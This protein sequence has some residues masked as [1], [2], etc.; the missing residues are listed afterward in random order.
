MRLFHSMGSGAH[1]TGM[2]TQR[3]LQN[4]QFGSGGHLQ[5]GYLLSAHAA[6]QHIT[7]QHPHCECLALAPCPHLCLLPVHREEGCVE[8]VKLDE[9][10]KAPR[11]VVQPGG[12][13]AAIQRDHVAAI[14]EV[15]PKV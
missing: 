8:A 5:D 11:R 14:A 1:V 12:P 3:S 15:G 2:N 6:S 4:Q 7:T 10:A 13:A 9:L